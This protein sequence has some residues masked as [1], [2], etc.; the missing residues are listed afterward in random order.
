AE[1]ATS[2]VFLRA[3]ERIAG[4]RGGS[5]AAWLFAITRNVVIDTYRQRQPLGLELVPEPEAGARTPEDW[6]VACAERDALRG[7]IAQLT[8]DQRTVIEL[9]LAGWTGPQIGS[10]TDRSPDAVKMLRY[11]AMKSLREAL[12]EMGWEKD[13]HHG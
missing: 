2:E 12:T 7:A 10:A 3:M 9:Q 4:Y 1:D 6:A 11:R 8:D 5:F 13:C